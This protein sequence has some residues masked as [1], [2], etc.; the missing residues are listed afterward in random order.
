MGVNDRDFD[1]AAVAVEE[2]E[3]GAHPPPVALTDLVGD[4]EGVVRRARRV[5]IPGQ[6][7]GSTHFGV[8]NIDLPPV[9]GSDGKLAI[10]VGHKVKSPALELS[11][12]S[13]SPSAIGNSSVNL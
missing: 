12:F 2:E 13:A 8:E 6:E 3:V 10:S 1:V 7:P 5:A 4:G 9:Q 11:T